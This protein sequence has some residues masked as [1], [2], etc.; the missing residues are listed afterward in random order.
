MISTY[1]SA[2]VAHD[3]RVTSGV[4]HFLSRSLVI[5]S[6]PTQKWLELIAHAQNERE[7]G[8]QTS[9]TCG[10]HEM[11]AGGGRENGRVRESAEKG[12]YRSPRL[13]IP[14]LSSVQ[15]FFLLL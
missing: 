12:S 11:R 4:C 15:V 9:P 3:N 10:Q 6:Q 2:V 8:E 13:A 14:F 5:N 7:R 1:S